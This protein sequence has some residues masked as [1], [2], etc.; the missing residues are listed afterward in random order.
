ME[1]RGAR[2]YYVDK[3]WS[4]WAAVWRKRITRFNAKI[5]LLEEAALATRS[6]NG[7]LEVDLNK[8]LVGLAGLSL[9]PN[10]DRL[11]PITSTTEHSLALHVPL[12]NATK[13]ALLRYKRGVAFVRRRHRE[14]STF[15]GRQSVVGLY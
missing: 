1:K 13:F 6:S 3:P 2:Y 12:K 5:K 14:V 4:M 8:A 10:I 15:R 11:P 9:H 7:S